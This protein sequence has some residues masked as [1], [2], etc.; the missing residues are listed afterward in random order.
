LAGGIEG[1]SG[2]QACAGMGGRAAEKETGANGLGNKE[3]RRKTTAR[4]GEA[5][6]RK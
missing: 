6:D 2:G 1:G 4:A 5:R 3:A